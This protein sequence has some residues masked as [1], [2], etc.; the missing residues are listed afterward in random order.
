MQG[1]YIELI[2][3]HNFLDENY[4]LAHR[5]QH[6]AIYFHQIDTDFDRFF[7]FKFQHETKDE[8]DF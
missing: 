3:N 7:F 6:F 5:I 4:I 8:I 2:K 1:I